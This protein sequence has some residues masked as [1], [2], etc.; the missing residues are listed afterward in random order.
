MKLIKVDLNKFRSCHD[1]NLLKEALKSG[2]IDYNTRDSVITLSVATSDT[3][4]KKLLYFEE[5]IDH[6][7][8]EKG[9]DFLIDWLC[10]SGLVENRR[11][12]RTLS[13]FDI[14]EILDNKLYIQSN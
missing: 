13:R 7:R 8:K 5:K 11:K 1:K 2:E 6:F 9:L 12:L 14:L 3:E 10:A 4:L